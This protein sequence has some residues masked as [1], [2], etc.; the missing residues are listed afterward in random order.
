[1]T[2]IYHDSAIKDDER[3]RLIYQG[4]LFI[5]SPIRASLEFCDFARK[6]IASAFHQNDPETAQDPH[7]C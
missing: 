3:R 2:A 6:M 7:A 4:D 5:Y 1:M